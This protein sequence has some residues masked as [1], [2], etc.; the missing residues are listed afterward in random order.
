MPAAK[1]PPRYVTDLEGNRVAVILDLD[2]YEQ[3]L[4][5]AEEL[6]EIRAY[7]EAKA[8][9]DEAIPFEQAIREIEQQRR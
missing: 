4:E 6:E 1:E 7:D 8:S 9:G 3:L 2:L 5:A